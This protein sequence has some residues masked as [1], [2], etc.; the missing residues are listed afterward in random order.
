MKEMIR[1]VWSYVKTIIMIVFVAL[2]GNTSV[3]EPS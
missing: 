3:K 2:G 1:K